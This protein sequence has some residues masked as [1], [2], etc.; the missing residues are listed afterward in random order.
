MFE[1]PGSSE[2][3][4][5]RPLGTTG[6]SVTPLCIGCAPLGNMP[7][8]FA[9]E[10]GEDRALAT[11]RAFLDSP[12]NF[13]DT[14]ASYGD[15]ESERRI[16]IVLRE[17]GGLPPGVVLASKADRDL[18][19]GEF[20]GAQMR[21]SVERS[22]RLLGL[23]QVQLMHLHDP[24]H[25]TFEEAMKPGGPVEVL[26]QCKEEGLVSHL[27][28]AGGPIDLM[29]RFVE[30]GLFEAVISH[31]RYTLLN[32]EAEPLWELCTR[33]N[34]AILN[35]APYGSGILA[36]GPSAYPRYMYQEAPADL[37]QRA[38][39]ME[40]LCKRHNVP[41]AAAA[42]QFSLRDPRITSTI[43]GLTRPERLEQ[44]IALSQHPIPDELW[45][46]LDKIGFAH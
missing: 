29:M 44:T 21:R 2:T 20:S 41:L 42:L 40:E 37:V 43:V 38:Q 17:R 27:G 22:L 45:G 31:N 9:Y 3:L 36:K 15:G 7:D 19:S 32:R 6:L 14:A 12:I 13:L 39:Q 8:T 46:E 24:E 10:V 35:A 28:V 30:T 1:K 34:V 16:G 5:L 18:K 23:E 11:I 4:K 26:Q 33:K 25:I